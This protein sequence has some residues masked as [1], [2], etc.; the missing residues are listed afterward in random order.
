M[1]LESTL[2]LAQYTERELLHTTSGS[3]TSQRDDIVDH[4]DI[5]NKM[6]HAGGDILNFDENNERIREEVA[7]GFALSE[8]PEIVTLQAPITTR[9]VTVSND[10]NS[11][12][13][14][15]TISTELDDWYIK[16]DSDDEI[17]RISDHTGGTNTATISGVYV[18]DNQTA[19]SCKIFKLRYTVSPTG[20]YLGI[21][22]PFKAKDNRK[23]SITDKNELRKR[24]PLFSV[25]EAFPEFSGILF[26]DES[27]LTVEMSHYSKEME[28]LELDLIPK[29][30]TLDTT[31]VNPSMP[32][33][34]RIVLAHTAAFFI[35][36][37]N[38]DPNAASHLITARDLF[39]GL[40]EWNSRILK[41]ADGDYGRIIPA[42]GSVG[43]ESIF[44]NT[45]PSHR[46]EFP[47]S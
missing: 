5:A 19:A 16:I 43:G 40:V 44:G 46:V 3:P 32:G 9:T 47:V 12:T 29:P 27:S 10:T 28:R 2:E 21:V 1:S 41:S 22:G 30:S 11:L 24:Y 7:F 25:S 42:Y 45:S 4:L 36:R 38:K 34:K 39:S 26:S 37:R 15:A 35:A 6:I 14:D 20:G 18:N 13:F 8:N 31:S 23:I 33:H 17:Y